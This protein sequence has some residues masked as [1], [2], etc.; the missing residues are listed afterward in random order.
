MLPEGTCI[1]DTT[2]DATEE[3]N[4]FFRGNPSIREWIMIL[5]SATYDIGMMYFL[6]YYGFT[7]RRVTLR[8]LLSTTMVGFAKVIFQEYV[9]TLGRLEGY[10]WFFPGVYSLN[11]PYFDINDFYFSGHLGANATFLYEFMC[12]SRNYPDSWFKT[13]FGFFLVLIFTKSLMM[14]VFR[15]HYSID[16][17]A[18]FLITVPILH[19]ADKLSYF[20]DIKV[21]GLRKTER[22]NQIM[23]YQVCS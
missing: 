8:M 2:F 16:L 3:Y 9:C 10:I 22:K 6:Y 17:I 21:M 1:R 14:I 11:V 7:D 5:D 18:G 19:A 20:F 15:A 12:A 13:L 23:L 4:L